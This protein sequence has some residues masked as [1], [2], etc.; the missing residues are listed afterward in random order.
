MVTCCYD[1]RDNSDIIGDIEM[2]FNGKKKAFGM[3]LR[4]KNRV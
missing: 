2:N 4:R 1:E 3:A